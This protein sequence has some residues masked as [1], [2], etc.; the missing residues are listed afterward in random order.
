MGPGLGSGVSELPAAGMPER[1]LPSLTEGRRC[2][3]GVNVSSMS[4]AGIGGVSGEALPRIVSS[5]RSNST[6]D[7]ICKKVGGLLVNTTLTRNSSRP[8]ISWL[9]SGASQVASIRDRPNP[10]ELAMPSSALRARSALA[11]S[12]LAHS[13]RSASMASMATEGSEPQARLGTAWMMRLALGDSLLANC[14]VC[15]TCA[16]RVSMALPLF[17]GIR[18]GASPSSGV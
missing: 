4:P 14:S 10:T 15:K 12:R 3:V 8:D 16:T 2:L 17:K 7:Q 5:Q 13:I 11:S 9:G 1:H 6:T 18:G